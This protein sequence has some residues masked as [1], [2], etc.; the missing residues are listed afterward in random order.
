MIERA[1]SDTTEPATLNLSANGQSSSLLPMKAL[2]VSAAPGSKYVGRQ[3]VQS[4]TLDL[5]QASLT[6]SPPFFVKL[7]LQGAELTALNGARKLLTATIACEVELSLADLYD[8]QS[9]W[10]E[11]V[12]LLGTAGFTICDIERVFID[13]V[14]G[15]LL[16]VNALLR[17]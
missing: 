17:R 14:S 13:P 5:L 10:H 4:T 6:T 12:A 9:P 2:H 3:V 15:D 11:V 8:G 16:Q 1:I 7:D